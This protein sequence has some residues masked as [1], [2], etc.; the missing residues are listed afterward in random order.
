MTL[1]DQC[2]VEEAAGSKWKMEV[3]SCMEMGVAMEAYHAG[4][5]VQKHRGQESPG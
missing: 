4:D 2:E 1:N 3:L 5:S